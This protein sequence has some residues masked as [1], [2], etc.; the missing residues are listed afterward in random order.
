MQPNSTK[1]TPA[2]LRNPSLKR[3]LQEVGPCLCG[4]SL[5]AEVGYLGS[6]R[7]FLIP[8]RHR[9]QPSEQLDVPQ[10]EDTFFP[11]LRRLLAKA[12]FTPL[13]W[14]LHCERGSVNKASRTPFPRSLANQ[15]PLPL[16]SGGNIAGMTPV[17]TK[18]PHHRKITHPHLSRESMLSEFL[19]LRMPITARTMVIN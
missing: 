9:P 5:H 15:L 6:V 4:N 2:D 16:H 7:V 18:R 10:L 13:T 17:R 19:S 12:K 1:L 11:K 3:G 8:S 14:G